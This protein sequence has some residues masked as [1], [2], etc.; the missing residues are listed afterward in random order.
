MPRMIS[1]PSVESWLTAAQ[2][3]IDTF[4]HD[5]TLHP[6]GIFDTC[7]RIVCRT[8]SPT[9]LF[10]LSKGLLYDPDPRAQLINREASKPF[11]SLEG[12]L[13][14]RARSVWE[15]LDGEEIG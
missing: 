13:T 6:M 1:S 14:P 3:H 15:H 11:P 5:L 4:G 12:I 7:C 2:T 9:I 8:C 10:T